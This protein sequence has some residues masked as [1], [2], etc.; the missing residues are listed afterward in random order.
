MTLTVMKIE[1]E[2]PPIG[3]IYLSVHSHTLY[4]EK[5]RIYN[6]G[7]IYNGTIRRFGN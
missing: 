6:E 1:Q 5:I 3:W 2:N 4:T 7:V